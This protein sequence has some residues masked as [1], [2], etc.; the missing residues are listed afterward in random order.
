[1]LDEPEIPL[2]SMGRMITPGGASRPRNY[3]R[4]DAKRKFAKNDFP[5]FTT[6]AVGE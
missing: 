4:P 2:G 6:L 3:P 5:A 1:M